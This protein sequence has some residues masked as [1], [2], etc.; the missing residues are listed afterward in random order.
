MKC[1][2]FLLFIHICVHTSA[3]EA[4][5]QQQQQ[6][7]TKPATT[8]THSRVGHTETRFD[9]RDLS[10]VKSIE[11]WKKWFFFERRNNAFSQQKLSRFVFIFRPIPSSSEFSS[12]GIKNFFSNGFCAAERTAI[13]FRSIASE[14]LMMFFFFV[15]LLLVL[16]R[17]KEAKKYHDNCFLT[18]IRKIIFGVSSVSALFF[19]LDASWF[20]CLNKTKITELIMCCG[21]LSITGHCN[22]GRSVIGTLAEA[23]YTTIDGQSIDAAIF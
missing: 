14:L 19:S 10:I 11:M 3:L 1:F 18:Y 20:R 8:A 15:L 12:F 4:K 2:L 9:I 21:P 16:R 6:V 13:T 22:F 23:L 17:N 5:K 7:K